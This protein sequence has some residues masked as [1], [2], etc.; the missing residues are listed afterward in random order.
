MSSALLSAIQRQALA[1]VQQLLAAGADPNQLWE[2]GD[3]PLTLA[4]TLGNKAILR[5]LVKAGADANLANGLG[6]VPLVVAAKAGDR[7]L[8]EY[9]GILTAPKQRQLAEAILAQQP[10]PPSPQKLVNELVLAA[11]AGNLSDVERLLGAGADARGV[12]D[13]LGHVGKTALYAAARNGH[14][15]VVD[16]LIA[17]GSDLEHVVKK[18]DLWAG[19]ERTCPQCD[20]AFVAVQDYGQCPHCK[21]KFHA[22]LPNYDPNAPRPSLLDKAKVDDATSGIR[23]TTISPQALLEHE[24]PERPP[25]PWSHHT[26]LMAA[27]RQNHLAV[28]KLLVQAGAD[29]NNAY[30]RH[31]GRLPLQIAVEAGFHEMA[32]CLIEAGSVL[33]RLEGGPSDEKTPLML[34]VSQS[35]TAMVE[36]LIKAGADVN[37]EAQLFGN[38]A[39]TVAAEP[40]DDAMIERLQA[41]GAKQEWL[42][43][44]RLRATAERGDL[45][46]VK[47]LLKQGIDPNQP[48]FRD[49]VPLVQ[50]AAKGHIE[51]V[52]CLLDAGAEINGAAGNTPLG[53]ATFCNQAEVVQQLIKAGA[54]VNQDSGF[55]WPLD[56]AESYEYQEVVSLLKA[57][58]ATERPVVSEEYDE[59]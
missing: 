41:A 53:L 51:V 48:D 28:V 40:G 45:A 52:Q 15:G 38:T 43:N 36:L 8:C 44:T 30:A 17:A 49:Q 16:C 6:E 55:G 29:V 9:L 19:V 3:R 10:E 33:D 32:Q 47:V 46:E 18:D 4:A 34:A 11:L 1:E 27:V 54:D 39:L 58:G 50:A 25:Q 22:S 2:E 35:D 26:A 59:F 57:A 42:E 14:A 24:Q 56:V 12:S 20:E 13:Q 31:Y 37:A 23:K 21:H 7:I 5:A